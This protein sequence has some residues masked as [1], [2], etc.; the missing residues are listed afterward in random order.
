M[1]MDV[2]YPIMKQI[3]SDTGIV[4]TKLWLLL[5]HR[6]IFILSSLKSVIT[7]IIE[8]NYA[9]TKGIRVSALDTVEKINITLCIRLKIGQLM[10]YHSPSVGE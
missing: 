5:L 1:K 6:C 2:N 9:R 3:E 7:Y 8:Y 4:P 10:Y